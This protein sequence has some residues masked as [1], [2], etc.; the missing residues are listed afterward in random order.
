MRN[1]TG[2]NQRS[3]TG[4]R[5]IAR[6]DDRPVWTYAG[7]IPGL[8]YVHRFRASKKQRWFDGNEV[9]DACVLPRS[10]HQR[11]ES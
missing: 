5:P 2:H 8:R 9:C 10:H 7:T 11:V 6:N 4:E 1:L 3:A